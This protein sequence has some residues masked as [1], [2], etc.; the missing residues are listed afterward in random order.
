MTRSMVER[1]LEDPRT[2]LRVKPTSRVEQVA[3]RA[4]TRP[5]GERFD[6]MICVDNAGRYL[7]VVRFERLVEALANE[8]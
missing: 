1:G 6:P 8:P 5:P 3:R 4:T 2:G 7:G